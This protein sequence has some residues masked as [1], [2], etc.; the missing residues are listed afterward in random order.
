MDYF[1]FFLFLSFS[2]VERCTTL[3]TTTSIVET[4]TTTTRNPRRNHNRNKARRQPPSQT[5]QTH[6]KHTAN[7]R[8]LCETPNKQTRRNETNP[9]TTKV[10]DQINR[11]HGQRDTMKFKLDGLDVF[12]PY[13]AIYPEQYE[14]MLEL[15]RSL[16][17]KGH[18]M[19]EMP[20]GTGKT[21]ALLA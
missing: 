18:C 4:T 11:V 13:P 17:A 9:Q 5:A 2:L 21:V 1:S 6:R 15:K 3:F 10:F 14:Y 16:D 12:F 20:T 7:P 8:N 19:L